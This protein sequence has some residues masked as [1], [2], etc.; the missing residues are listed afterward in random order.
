MKKTHAL[1]AAALVVA[2]HQAGALINDG[3]HK[4]PGELFVSIYD[5][6]GARSYYKDLGIT[7][8]D[9]IDGKGCFDGDL[10]KDPNY[11]SFSS[12]AKALVYNIAAVNPL[13]RDAVNNPVNITRWGYLAT[14]S[15]G[16]E[17]FNANWNSI[18]N[19][20]QKI[21]AFIAD[22]NVVPFTGDAA[23]QAENR[24]G[25]FQSNGIGYHGKPSWGSSMGRSVGGNT[26]GVPGAPLD[27]YFINNSN[28]EA[29]GRQVSK[30]GAWNLNGSQL[31]YSG[32]GTTAVCSGATGNNFRLTVTKTGTGAGTVISSPA[33]I[34]CGTACAADF[35]NGTAVQLGAAASAGAT[36]T[37]WTAGPCQGSTALTCVVTMNSAVEVA[38]AFSASEPT[39]PVD[40]NKPRLSLKAPSSFKVKQA[41]NIT[42]SPNLITPK[43]KV[44]IAYSKNGGAKFSTL[45]SVAV[46]RGAFTWKPAKSHVSS[47]GVIRACAPPDYKR[48]KVQICEI[49]RTVVQP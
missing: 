33:G 40:P 36:F 19:T 39:T 35:A 49:V 20:Q 32:T 47:Q 5:E 8:T 42:W 1:M 43:S 14:S 45:K 7:M 9:F 29:S 23:Q 28:G 22:L 30:L 2:S 6:A 26:E 24:S 10:S 21:Q 44:V 17:I 46:T 27:F 48:K 41:Q 16:G 13:V 34:N 4:A 25:I 12:G 18:D 15:A 38:A 37:G 11:A 3:K 31:S